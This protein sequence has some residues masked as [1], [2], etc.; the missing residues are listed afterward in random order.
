[1]EEVAA[2]R[3]IARGRPHR[4]SLKAMWDRDEE[5]RYVCGFCVWVSRT[6]A[7]RHT[8]SDVTE[9]WRLKRILQRHAV[10]FGMNEL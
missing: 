6:V 10:P 5:R 1:M 2:T 3:G 8:S 7:E 4:A 9:D